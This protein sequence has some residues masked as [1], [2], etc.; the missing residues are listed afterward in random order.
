[1]RVEQLGRAVANLNTTYV[2]AIPWIIPLQEP[3]S[4]L[5]LYREGLLTLGRLQ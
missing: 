5:V 3:G 1:M 2:V 4:E